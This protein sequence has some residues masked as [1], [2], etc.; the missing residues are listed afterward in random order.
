MTK[1]VRKAKSS[2]S[3]Y[4]TKPLMTAGPKSTK[5]ANNTVKRVA[6]PVKKGKK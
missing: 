3:A 5:S 1:V 6:A 4:G 2:P